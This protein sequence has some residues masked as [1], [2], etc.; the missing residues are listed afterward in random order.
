MNVKKMISLF[1]KWHLNCGFYLLTLLY[2]K[3][4][5][6]MSIIKRNSDIFPNLSR[7][8]NDDFFNRDL[9]DWG[10]SN[11]GSS[12]PAVNIK[13]TKENFEVEM[14]APG[15]NKNDFKIEVDDNMLTIS[16][17]KTEDREE[18]SDGEK[19]VR[20][21]FS[22]QSFERSFNLPKEVDADKIEAHYEDGVLQLT[23][24]K[25]EQAKQKKARTI[26]V[27]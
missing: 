5:G 13:E 22:Y 12:I 26:S 10:L 20:R 16:A 21:E 4:G 27:V 18:R 9:S 6:V 2:Y 14:A 11:S 19:E 1:M 25:K 15:M 3:K 8:W 24:P 17:E 23:I 7:F